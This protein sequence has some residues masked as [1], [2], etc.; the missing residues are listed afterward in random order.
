M[1]EKK[2]R[3]LQEKGKVQFLEHRIWGIFKSLL[4]HSYPITGKR[5]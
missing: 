3:C 4:H 1:Q 5:L 2:T